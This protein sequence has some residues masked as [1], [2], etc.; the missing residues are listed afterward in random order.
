MTSWTSLNYTRHQH[1]TWNIIFRSEISTSKHRK[2]ST[3][4]RKTCRSWESP[5]AELKADGV[6]PST[7]G[8]KLDLPPNLTEKKENFWSLWPDD[9]LVSSQCKVDPEYLLMNKIWPTCWY[10][11]SPALLNARIF[12]VQHG[13]HTWTFFFLLSI[14]EHQISIYMYI[15]VK[16]WTWPT[17]WWWNVRNGLMNLNMYILICI[18]TCLLLSHNVSLE[19]F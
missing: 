10:D 12:T 16:L 4:A 11:E 2:I 14:H 19:N 13:R 3:Q 8:K 17:W 6:K 18:Y 9:F 5:A 1:P 7:G 15:L